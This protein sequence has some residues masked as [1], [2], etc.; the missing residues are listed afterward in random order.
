MKTITLDHQTPDDTM[1]ILEKLKANGHTDVIIS[2]NG[3][4]KVYNIDVY[5]DILNNY[6]DG[7]E[8]IQEHAEHD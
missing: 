3:I 8:N 4:A 5:L 1:D 7:L 6:F 2:Y